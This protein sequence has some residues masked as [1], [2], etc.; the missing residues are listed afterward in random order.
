MK[1]KELAE[2]LRRR[3][4]P[5]L[6]TIRDKASGYYERALKGRTGSNSSVLYV[7][8]TMR[9]EHN[10]YLPVYIDPINSKIYSIGNN[11]YP[12]R[13]AGWG[14]RSRWY[15]CELDWRGD[16]VPV[17]TENV[18]VFFGIRTFNPLYYMFGVKRNHCLVAVER[19][20]A[21]EFAT[22]L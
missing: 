21:D 14:R 4:V 12:Y 8:R 9:N 18:N 11:S 10:V 19:L 7:I 15:L 16:G 3:Y 17:C 1:S 20:T 22:I 2:L 13:S 5:H 6:L